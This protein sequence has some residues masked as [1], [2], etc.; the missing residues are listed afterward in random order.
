MITVM[1]IVGAFAPFVLIVPVLAGL[2]LLSDRYL[3]KDDCYV[4][5]SCDKIHN[6]Y[7]KE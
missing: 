6:T 7:F 1:S 3:F 5:Q 2:Q 4:Q